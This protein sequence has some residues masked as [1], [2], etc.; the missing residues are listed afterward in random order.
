MCCRRPAPMRLVPF[1]Y[2][3]TCWNV[4]PSASATSVWLLSSISRRIRTR[5][6]TCLSVGL[7]VPLGICASWQLQRYSA[8]VRGRCGRRRRRCSRQGIDGRRGCRRRT[9]GGR[10]TPRGRRTGGRRDR[11]GVTVDEH[12]HD[13]RRDGGND[14]G[15]HCG[16]TAVLFEV[17]A[18][19]L[20]RL[21]RG[22]G[23]GVLRQIGHVTSP[24][25]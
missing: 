11:Y 10:R 12:N 20:V 6:P 17:E 16:A 23:Q 8:V 7:R 21:G 5:L 19:K 2:F 4:S 15:P 1:S 18:A 25:T 14:P 3:W 13:N 22:I 24:L 9:S